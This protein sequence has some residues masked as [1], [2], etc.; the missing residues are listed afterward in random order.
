MDTGAG[1]Q[2]TQRNKAL[3]AKFIK[4]MRLV[5]ANGFVDN[6]P[7][8]KTCLQA[9]NLYNRRVAIAVMSTTAVET[10]YTFQPI[11]EMGGEKYLR[12]KPYYPY[13]GRGFFQLTWQ[14]NYELYGQKIGVNLLA[15]PD[16]ALDPDAS[17]AI[18]ASYT[19]D[20][21][22]DMA[23]NRCDWR[24]CRKKVNGGYNGLTEFLQIVDN[25]LVVYGG[26]LEEDV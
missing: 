18:L 5:R 15:N 7:R 4:A 16:L 19:K 6:W 22:L 12:A 23:A 25:L 24:A 14:K 17:A 21:G 13:Y 8:I 20:T 9:L 26:M 3:D 2:P 11:R 10:A 1:V